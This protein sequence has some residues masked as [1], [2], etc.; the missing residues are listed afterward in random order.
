MIRKLP[1]VV[2]KLLIPIAFFLL[3]ILIA[4][5]VSPSRADELDDV[6]S[7]LA[8]QQQQL[9]DLEKRQQQLSR[10]ISSASLSLSQVS[11]QL[12]AAEKELAEIEKELDAKEDELAKW[13][14]DRDALVRELYKQNRVSSLEII[15]SAND[16]EESAHHFQYYN[17][18]LN[19]LHSTIT[20]LT[21]EIT[22]FQ[23]NRTAAK[24]LRD[25]LAVLRSQYTASLSYSRSQFSSTSSQLASVKSSIKNLT[26][27]QEQLILEKFAAT[28]QSETIGDKSPLSEPLPPTSFFPAWMIATYGYPHRVGMNQYGAYGRALVA[29]QSFSTI[30]KAYYK[31]VTIGKYSVPSTIKVSGYGSIS[32]EDNYLRGISEMPRSWPMEVLKAQAVAARTYALNWVQARPGESICTTQSCQVYS[33]S[34]EKISCSG[35]YN[36]RWCDAVDATKGIVITYGGS[37]IAAYYASTAG[38]YT[39]SSQEVWG[40]YRAWAQGIKDYACSGTGDKCAFDGP[41]YGKSPW[42]HTGWGS[43]NG[44][45]GE[46]YPW[47]TQEEFADIFNALLICTSYGQ[48]VSN[49]GYIKYLSPIDKDVNNDGKINDNDAWRMQTLRNKLAELEIPSY[50][51]ISAVVS[52]FT[53]NGSNTASVY[54]SGSGGTKTFA[55]KDFWAIFN[56]RS[57]GTLAIRTYRFDIGYCASGGCTVPN[58][59]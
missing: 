47:M 5:S 34:S 7:D 8:R 35:T 6:T 2:R 50:S 20:K 27:K 31:G 40:G 56:L 57:R 23:S 53:S 44:A 41:A 36:K 51:S 26:A 1:K 24:K 22:V 14:A 38:G 32:F 13:E 29:K 15:F 21:E 25:D 19:T 11:I 43:R 58:F 16:L 42:Y 49:C 30:L 12:T 17:A 48:T 9:S 28:S 10:D 46:Y 39:L 55:A 3:A 18:N 45:K 54:I 37:P 52:T 4:F 59:K 33:P